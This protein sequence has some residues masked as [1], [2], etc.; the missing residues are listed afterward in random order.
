MK[1]FSQFLHALAL[2]VLRL[3]K[4]QSRAHQAVDALYLSEKHIIL[5]AG[6]HRAEI[7]LVSHCIHNVAKVTKF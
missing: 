4:R 1:G 5:L 2:E 7:T 3:A 6:S